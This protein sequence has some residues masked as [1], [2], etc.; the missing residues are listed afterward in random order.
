MAEPSADARD[1]G[2]GAD[3]AVLGERVIERD[4]P[5][6][7]RSVRATGKGRPAIY[8]SPGCRHLAWEMRRAEKVL[9]TPADT[10]PTVVRE[11]VE[12]VVLAAPDPATAAATEARGWV[13]V[14]G[15]LSAQ[16]AQPATPLAREHWQHRRLYRALIEALDHLDA[17]HPGGLDQLK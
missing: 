10:R 5:T 14:L 17:A 3:G 13:R 7:G 11:V 8:C 1:S 15:H 12:R 6:C 4:C 2:A 9:G 16:L